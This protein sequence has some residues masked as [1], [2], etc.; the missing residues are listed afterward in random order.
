MP[1]AKEVT[2]LLAARAIH[3]SRF[4]GGF[5]AKHGL[6]AVDQIADFREHRHGLL[7]VAIIIISALDN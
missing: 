4:I 1:L 7:I 3:G 6:K 5:L 2:R